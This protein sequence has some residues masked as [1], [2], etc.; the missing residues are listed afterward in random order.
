LAVDVEVSL[1][2]RATSLKVEIQAIAVV[3]A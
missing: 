3:P 2:H 1:P